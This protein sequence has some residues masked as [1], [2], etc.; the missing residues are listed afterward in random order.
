MKHFLNDIEISPRNRTEIGIVSTFTDD[1]DVLQLSTDTIVLPREGFDII[2]SHIQ[3]I[4]VFEGIPYRVELEGG[5]FINYYVDLTDS[6]KV[7]QH[8]VEVKIKKRKGQDSFYENAN[9][10]SFEMMLSK[11]V[12]FDTFKVPYFVIKDNQVELAISLFITIYVLTKETIEAAK[13]LVEAIKDVIQACTP[14]VGVPPSVNTGAIITAVLMA[15]ARLVYFAALLVALLAMASKLF[16]L[17][18]PIKYNLLGCK[19]KELLS[20]GCG[21][22]GYTF[23]SNLLDAIP[24]ATILPVPLVRDR[25]S[26]FEWVPDEFVQPFSKGI[27]SASDTTPTLGSL[28]DAICIMFN[29]RIKVNNGVVRLERWDWWQTQSVN[30]LEPA[31]NLQ[32]DRDD[33]YTL[34][35]EDI[36]KR[37]YIKYQMDSMDLN[38]YDKLYDRHDAEFSTEPTT[39]INQDLVCIKGL[40]QVDIPFAL[41]RRKEKLNW[42]EFIGK[43]MFELVDAVTGLFGNGTSYGTQIGERKDCMQVSEMFFST[44]KFL[45]TVNGKQ[46]S[47]YMDYISAKGLWDNYHYINQ[48]QLNAWKIK[49]ETR[50]RLTSSEFVTL[51]D[52]NYVEIGG[53]IC[54]VLSCEWIDE[55]SLATITYR[56]P[57]NYALG[58]VTTVTINE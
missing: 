58:K 57:S 27:P 43:E 12:V 17:F 47:N 6:L 1:P 18:F 52:N 13:E 36:W 38:T 4:G 5:I 34:N 55:K 44:T 10:S 39:V 49:S 2:T 25:K 24:Q 15:A 7:N 9:G 35:V 31:L 54:E 14:N 42:L 26:I 21:Y 23:E 40:N 8:D 29:G 20:K 19:V 3:T 45:Y 51:L 53:E 30:L 46:P 56:I 48:I 11:G 28:I 41:G 33:T 22:L 37:Y 32:G 50:I 16:V